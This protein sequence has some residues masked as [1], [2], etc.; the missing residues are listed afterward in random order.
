MRESTTP[1]SSWTS[2]AMLSASTPTT[3]PIKRDDEENP[4]GKDWSNLKSS[5][6]DS[7][8]LEY[9]LATRSRFPLSV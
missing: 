9:R 7:S 3:T 6:L 8:T 1:R 4:L 5:E 2:S